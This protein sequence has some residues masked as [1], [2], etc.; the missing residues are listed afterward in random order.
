MDTEVTVGDNTVKKVNLGEAGG[1]DFSE[2]P[3]MSTKI[4]IYDQKLYNIGK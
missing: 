3:E 2:T 4:Q 1:G